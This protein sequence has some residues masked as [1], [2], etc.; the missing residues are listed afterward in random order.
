MTPPQGRLA[1]VVSVG[2]VVIAMV[3]Y[4]AGASIARGLIGEVGAPGAAALRLAFGTAMLTAAFRP[5]RLL[6]QV[7]DWRPV[8]AYGVVLGLMNLAFYA[9]IARIPLGLAVALEFSGPLAVAASGARR[10][11]DFLW[12]GLAVVG[13]L[14][15]L[16]PS[17]G[18]LT[19]LDPK[20]VAFAFGAG[21]CWALYIVFGRKAG[22]EHGIGAAALGMVIAAVVVIPVGA[23]EAGAALV[24]P[25]AL[26]IGAVVGLMCTAVPYALEMFAMTR[27]PAGVFGIL[28]SLEP[29]I[30]AL[31][32]LVLLH[33]QLTRLQWL[34]MAAV[35]SA[36]AGATATIGRNAVAVREV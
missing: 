29:G 5:W 14:L 9:A 3:G 21:A 2:A 25:H 20:G 35:I 28:M 10:P 17:G 11:L 1:V 7:R 15:I 16:R 26:I 22:G 27:M 31:A 6:S 18:A 4:Q 19:S 33:Q 23:A 34:A 30:A 32:G 12:V 8:I 13:L 24:T 36:S